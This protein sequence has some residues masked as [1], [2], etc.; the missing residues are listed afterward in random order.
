MA[1][2]ENEKS[3]RLQKE[4]QSLDEFRQAIVAS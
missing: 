4:K 3:K 2:V 1:A